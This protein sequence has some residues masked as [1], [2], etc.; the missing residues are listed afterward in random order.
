MPKPNPRYWLLK[1]EPTTYSFEKL[2]QQKK[3]HWDGVRNYQ[4]R[5]FLAEM[6]KDDLALIY[7][8]GDDKAIVGLARVIRE[9]YPDPDPKK[10]GEWVQL[11]LESVRPLARPIR[12]AE[13]KETAAL[14]DLMLIRQSRLSVMPVTNSHAEVLLGL[15][16]SA[17]PPQSTAAKKRVTKR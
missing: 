2:V 15:E 13:L 8:S 6:K 9:G 17:A 4:A 14:K 16:K 5:N 10:P 7:H 11:D 12:L 3:T 1:T